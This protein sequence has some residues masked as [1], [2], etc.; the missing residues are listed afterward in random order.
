MCY[1][2][3][4]LIYAWMGTEPCWCFD[5]EVIRTFSNEVI[6]AG[7]VELHY[8]IYNTNETVPG[9]PETKETFDWMALMRVW[10]L[11]R[12]LQR[13]VRMNSDTLLEGCC[14][15]TTTLHSVSLGLLFALRNE[16]SE[17]WTKTGTGTGNE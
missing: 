14:F 6:Q 17:M 8:L 4:M 7:A 3:L 16:Y 10:R 12:I 15:T 5:L 13:V 11:A 2:R 9:M 1:V